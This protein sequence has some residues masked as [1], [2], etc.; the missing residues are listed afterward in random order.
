[1]KYAVRAN[2]I[3]FVAP[4][5]RMATIVMA[6]FVPAAVLSIVA[7]GLLPQFDLPA[8]LANIAWGLLFC[9]LL[10]ASLALFSYR[11]SRSFG[12]KIDKGLGLVTLGRGKQVC[13]EQ[14]GELQSLFIRA[15]RPARRGGVQ[16]HVYL[17]G[18]LQCLPLGIIGL[19]E[20]RARQKISPL[21]LFLELP[22]VVVPGG[23]EERD[24]PVA[25]QQT[26][27]A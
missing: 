12:L 9:S 11:S 2:T 16:Y 5:R 3:E 18:S 19:T 20:E 10:V 17:A 1:M 26:V 23:L 4:E 14:V 6:V 15:V 7:L 24:M 25:R 8:W 22:V 13:S 27:K 21:S